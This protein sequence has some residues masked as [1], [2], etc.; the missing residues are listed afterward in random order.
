MCRYARLSPCLRLEGHSI[1]QISR[2][3]VS[4]CFRSE[5]GSSMQR[6]TAPPRLVPTIR[7][8]K[9]R[10]SSKPDHDG[11][12]NEKAEESL[13]GIHQNETPSSPVSDSKSLW[14]TTMKIYKGL[15]EVIQA[16]LLPITV[17]YLLTEGIN[18]LSNRAFHRLTNECALTFFNDRICLLVD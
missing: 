4:K 16:N 6:Y 11:E 2:R 3:I 7:A 15:F 18:F 10:R 14:G 8:K 17:V 12:S 1:A 9:H 13:G 5:I